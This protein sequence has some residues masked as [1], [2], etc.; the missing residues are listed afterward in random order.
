MHPAESLLALG[1]LAAAFAAILVLLRLRAPLWAAI[2]AGSAVV[3]VSAGMGAADWIGI[4]VAVIWQKDFLPFCLMVFLIL[5]LSS[6]QEDTGQSRLLVEGLEKHLRRPHARLVIFPALI[7]LLPMPGGALFSCPMIRAAAKDMRLSDQKKALLNYWFR[8][9]WELSWPLYPGYVL[10]CSLLDIPL[11]A[12]CRATFPMIP[13]AFVIGCF[14]FLRDLPPIAENSQNVRDSAP[15][16]AGGDDCP[17]TPSVPENGAERRV[18]TGRDGDPEDPSLGAALLHALPIFVTLAGAMACSLLFSAFLPDMSSLLAFSPAL[19]CAVG[20]CLRQGRRRRRRSL[21]SLALT[22]NA[23]GILVLLFAIFVFKQAIMTSGL[24]E[25]LGKAGVS[26]AMIV[27]SCIALPFIGGLLTGLMA[28]FVGV[29]FPIIIGILNQSSMQE[30]ATPLIILALVAGNAGQLLSP[31]HVC[32]V[33]TGEFF[34]T[35]IAGMLRVLLRPVCVL[36]VCGALWALVALAVG[37]RL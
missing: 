6:V 21:A 30:Y 37:I 32:L 15:P 11:S 20:V 24:L 18:P 22:A 16:P 5:L 31:L 28:G 33:V 14:F 4:V 12:L 29:S 3:C 8:H 7:G 19:I 27:V 23:R 36:F 25:T 35:P 34:S 1:K 2:V 17:R 26:G 13:L 10:T 9:I